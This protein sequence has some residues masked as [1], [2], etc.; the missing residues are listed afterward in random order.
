M[1]FKDQIKRDT[2]RVYFNTTE[3]ADI[4]IID[5]REVH[6]MQ[7]DDRILENADLTLFAESTVQSRIFV[8]EEEMPILP[9]SGQEITIN[10]AKWYIR[11]SVNNEGVYELLIGRSKIY[12]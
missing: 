2:K 7:D 10:G 1:G 4:Y 12:D 8:M 5:G 3:F 6:V 11:H 9:L